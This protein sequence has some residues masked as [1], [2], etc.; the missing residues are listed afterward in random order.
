MSIETPADAVPHGDPKIETLAALYA[1]PDKLLGAVQA[2]DDDP[3]V[4]IDTLSVVGLKAKHAFEEATGRRV[5]T[6]EG[7]SLAAEGASAGATGGAVV[8][9]VAGLLAGLGVFVLPG[10][11]ALIAAGPIATT[12][13]GAGGGAALGG[14]SGALVGAGMKPEHAEQYEAALRHGYALAI[15]RAAPADRVRSHL[16]AFEPVDLGRARDPG[17]AHARPVQ[18]PVPPVLP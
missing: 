17:A 1:S 13:A 7:D 11:G 6:P 4:T 14:A 9:A 10:I 15:V 16:D 3:L 18:A 2:L 5:Q 12:L 8:G